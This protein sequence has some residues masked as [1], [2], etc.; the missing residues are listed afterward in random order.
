[1]LLV[2]DEALVRTAMHRFLARRGWTVSEAV[3]GDCA[4]TLLDPIAGI[5][6]DLVICDLQMPRLSGREFY[7]WLARVRPDLAS[8][9]V[10]SSGDLL[11]PEFAAFLTETG[12]PVL[13]KPFD[14][15]ELARIVEEV[16]ADA[17]AA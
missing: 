3:D 14:L 11:S 4:R 2:D 6:F 15:S 9:L 8:R 5:E 13:P 17:H 12:R 10:F 7:G 16:Y 1:V